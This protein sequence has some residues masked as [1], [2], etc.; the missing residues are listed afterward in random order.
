MHLA[1]DARNF[2]VG[3]N[4]CSGVVIN[5]GRPAFENR[6]HDHG[7]RFLRHV[8]QRFRGWPGHGLGQLEIC[9]VFALAE[10]LRAKKF[11]QADDLGSGAGSFFNP[12]LG[13]REIFLRLGAYRH[14]YQTNR[15]FIRRCH[16]RKI[17]TK[18]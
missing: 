5:T 2:A 8:A 10:V 4:N 7:F 12:R 1:I 18:S 15:E 6:R 9:G 13:A 3:I 17:Y 14:L 16:N 11:R